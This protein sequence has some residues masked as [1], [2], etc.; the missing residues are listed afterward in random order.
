[1][2]LTD[3]PDDPPRL[4]SLPELPLVRR[5]LYLGVFVML[6]MVTQYMVNAAD[7][8]MVARLPDT[9]EATAWLARCDAVEELPEASRLQHAL[10]T[11]WA[12]RGDAPLA[13]AEATRLRVR[14]LDHP[15]AVD[16]WCGLAV[17]GALG[18][19]APRAFRRG[20]GA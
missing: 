14:V 2:N 10:V 13:P 20:A 3:L 18:D 17:R 9:A 1:M 6:A 19:D 12:S 15:I 4:L 7:T 5:V 11:A 16:S 8:L